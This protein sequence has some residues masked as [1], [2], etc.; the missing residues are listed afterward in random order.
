MILFIVKI[1]IGVKG[2]YQNRSKIMVYI[3]KEEIYNL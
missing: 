2:Q 1:Q 3:N